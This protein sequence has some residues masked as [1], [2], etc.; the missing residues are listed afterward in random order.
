[1]LCTSGLWIT[2]FLHAMA[3]RREK[4]VY[5]SQSNSPGGGTH[6]TPWHVLRLTHQGAVP[7]RGRSLMSTI[8][9]LQLATRREGQARL[10][11]EHSV[12][13]YRLL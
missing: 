13:L 9:L 7:D 12:V 3:K 11:D 8:A 5:A 6:L 1:M 4:S 2:S 10:C